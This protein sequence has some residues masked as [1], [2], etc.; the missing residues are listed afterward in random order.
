MYHVDD[1]SEQNEHF[2]SENKK[3]QHKSSKHNHNLKQ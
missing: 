1:F 3:Y 2:C